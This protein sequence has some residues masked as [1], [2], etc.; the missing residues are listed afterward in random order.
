VDPA[1]YYCIDDRE[2]TRDPKTALEAVYQ[3]F[4]WI[5]D[6][7]FLAALTEANQRQRGFKSKHEYS[8]EEFGLSKE[9]IQAKLGPLMDYYGLPR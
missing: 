9:L 3:H 8:L 7:A 1:R 6:G 4:G 2:L 5:P